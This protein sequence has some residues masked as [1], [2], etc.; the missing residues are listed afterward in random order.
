MAEDL[1]VDTGRPTDPTG[2]YRNL[3][4]PGPAPP[5]DGGPDCRVEIGAKIDIPVG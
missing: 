2:D 1:R 5:R 3:E 4:F